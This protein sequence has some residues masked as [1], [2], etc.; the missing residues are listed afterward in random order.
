MRA[1][2]SFVFGSGMA[3]EVSTI[4]KSQ[5]NATVTCVRLVLAP[6]LAAGRPAGRGGIPVRGL[7][8][9][10]GAVVVAGPAARPAGRVRLAVPYGVCVR[11]VAAAARRAASARIAGGAR[12]L[13]RAPPV[14][15]RRVGT[16]RRAG[17]DRGA[18]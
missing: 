10:R 17:R 1:G 3:L 2:G 16:I 7:A 12:G 11:G 15:E 8:R 4:C 13:R 6:D 14:L 9:G 18:G 5:T